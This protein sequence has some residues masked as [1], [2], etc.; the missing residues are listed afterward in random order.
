MLIYLLV[1]ISVGSD[2][3]KGQATFGESLRKEG[4]DCT[5]IYAGL[6][7]YIDVS[8]VSARCIDL[9]LCATK[10]SATDLVFSFTLS[11]FFSLVLFLASLRFLI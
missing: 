6:W 7:L 4:I 1:V 11:S 2:S 5:L 10:S 8:F 9:K 3:T